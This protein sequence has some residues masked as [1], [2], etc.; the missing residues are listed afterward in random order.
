MLAFPQTVLPSQVYFKCNRNFI[1]EMPSLKNY[2]RE[3]YSIPGIARAVNIYH[4]KVRPAG[5]RVWAPTRP[6]S[7]GYTCLRCTPLCAPVGH[8]AED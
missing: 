2:V 8:Q 3:L 6:H 5:L 4:I 7:S 1:Y